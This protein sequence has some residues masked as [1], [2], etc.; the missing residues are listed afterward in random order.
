[1]LVTT[2]ILLSY[3]APDEIVEYFKSKY[4]DGI[5]LEKLFDNEEKLELLHFVVK[6]L[7]ISEQEKSKYNI[8]CRITDSE[9]VYNSQL[10]NGSRYIV[11]SAEVN[12]SELVHESQS[13]YYSKSIYDSRE[14]KNSVDVWKS[15]GVYDSKKIMLSENIFNSEDIIYSRDVSWSQVIN[16]S[17]SIEGSKAIYKSNNII[18]SC[19][20][21]FCNDLSNSLFCLNLH[22]KNYQIFNKDVNANE[23]ET[24]REELLRK[25]EKEDFNFISV[26]SLGY[27]A[28]D[29]Y[30]I[31]V[32]FD[33]MF[34]NLSSD[35]CNWVSSLPNYSEEL[36]LALFFKG[37]N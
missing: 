20:C 16:N 14:V 31:S 18:N 34:R 15:S 12:Y 33:Y 28:K 23:F 37:S 7:K 26:D 2:N 11:N 32:R 22:G 29:K 27:Y 24:A 21:G 8:K 6:Y 35:F 4:P 17:N 5:E 30:K 13:I 3:N 25:L 9:N 1:M 19:F 10:I 36:F